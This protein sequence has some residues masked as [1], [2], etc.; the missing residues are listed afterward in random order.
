M[1]LEIMGTSVSW[2]PKGLSRPGMGWLY[3][4]KLLIISLLDKCAVD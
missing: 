1:I 2:S 4:A 3:C